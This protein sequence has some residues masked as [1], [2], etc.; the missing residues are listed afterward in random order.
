LTHGW[1]GC[2]GDDRLDIAKSV[3]CLWNGSS[4]AHHNDKERWKQVD[5]S[6]NDFYHYG[7]HQMGFAGF[8][9]IYENKNKLLSEISE[10][11][12]K[13]ILAN[14]P[15]SADWVRVSDWWNY[16]ENKFYKIYNEHRVITDTPSSDKISISPQRILSGIRE[17]KFLFVGAIF[18]GAITT[19]FLLTSRRK[20]RI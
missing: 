3:R 8:R 2:N 15:S 16:F 18:T 13:N 1:G 7:I 4:T 6:W 11:R 19:F 20:V 17:N 9:E 12:R 10:T 5:N 14:K